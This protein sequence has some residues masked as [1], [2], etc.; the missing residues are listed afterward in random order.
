MDTAYMLQVRLWAALLEN[1]GVSHGTYA[2][3]R[4]PG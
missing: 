2:V 3:W 4:G 1:A